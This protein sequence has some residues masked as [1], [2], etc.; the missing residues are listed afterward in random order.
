[1]KTRV[2]KWGNSLAI[3]IPAGMAK[4]LKLGEGV[5]VEV[6]LHD[7]Y[8]SI[9]RAAEDAPTLEELLASVKPDQ[10]HGETDWGPPRGREEW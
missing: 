10:L 5:A 1:M 3:R 7:Q 8:L 6:A 2:Q 9:A 4:E